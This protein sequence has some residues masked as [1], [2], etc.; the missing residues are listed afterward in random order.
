MKDLELKGFEEIGESDE[1]SIQG[2]YYY[3]CYYPVAVLRQR[4][5]HYPVAVVKT[6]SGLYWW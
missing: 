5:G 3:G 6:A 1:R 4:P 2:G